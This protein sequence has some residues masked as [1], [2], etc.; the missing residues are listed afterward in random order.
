[1]GWAEHT[2]ASYDNY[3]GYLNAVTGYKAFELLSSGSNVVILLDEAQS[4]YW[5]TSF[6]TDFL[7]SINPSTGPSVVLFCSFGSAGRMVFNSET[8]FDVGT[9]LNL[10]PQQ[11]ISLTPGPHGLGLLAS[12]EEARD[13][14]QR[15]LHSRSGEMLLDS[16]LVDYLISIT[17]GHV[18][19][20]IGF[21]E[22]LRQVFLI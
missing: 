22:A 14:V 18:G 12:E 8:D 7:K 16:Q 11:R 4:T 3:D 21:L 17:E 15:H 20:M 6:W 5:D 10:R 1:V 9:P 19:A 13:I 2:I